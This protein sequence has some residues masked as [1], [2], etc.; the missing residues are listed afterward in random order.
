MLDLLRISSKMVD[1]FT[2]FTLYDGKCYAKLNSIFKLLVY[3]VKSFS[4]F[5]I[6]PNYKVKILNFPTIVN[7]PNDLTHFLGSMETL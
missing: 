1:F 4:F 3:N 5:V 7:G 2:I 6:G